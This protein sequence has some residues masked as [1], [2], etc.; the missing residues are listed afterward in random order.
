MNETKKMFVSFLIKIYLKIYDV[1]NVMAYT[2]F[3]GIVFMSSGAPS[4]EIYLFIF[5]R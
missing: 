1:T 4:L 5:T 2:F 3:V